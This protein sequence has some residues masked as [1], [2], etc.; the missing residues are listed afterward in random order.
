MGLVEDN[1]F[2]FDLEPLHGIVL[3]NS[4]LDSNTGLAPSATSHTVT[5]T[6]EHNVEVH[7]IDTSRR[8]IPKG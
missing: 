6:L 3:G 8:I 7:T 5:G 4:V 2:V 1:S